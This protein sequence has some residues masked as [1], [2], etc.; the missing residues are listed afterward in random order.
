MLCQLSYRPVTS[1]RSGWVVLP[2]ALRANTSDP[3]YMNEMWDAAAVAEEF[4]EAGIE[5]QVTVRLAEAVRA[6]GAAAVPALGAGAFADWR[7]AS[8]L[9]RLIAD[10]FDAGATTAEVAAELEVVAQLQSMLRH[11]F[12]LL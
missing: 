5:P 3:R 7:T 11:E 2:I 6:N 8:A 4:T 1:K 9:N 12:A 10:A